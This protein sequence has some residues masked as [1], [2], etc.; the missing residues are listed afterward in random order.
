MSDG[1]NNTGDTT[2]DPAQGCGETDLKGTLT[3]PTGAKERRAKERR[4]WKQ[5]FLR[6]LAKTGN[7]TASARRA[8]INPKHAHHCYHKWPKFAQAWDR[9]MVQAVDSLEKAAWDR[10][11]DGLDKPIYQ[12]GK[13]VGWERRYSDT[14][15]IF[16]L[17]GR[18]PEV[19]GEKRT[20]GDT[21]VNV[22]VQVN[23]GD[24]SGEPV[25]LSAA[26]IEAARA[27][28]A[29]LDTISPPKGPEALPTADPA[30]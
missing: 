30:G 22:G 20:G 28:L 2:P 3:N 17:K 23:Q 16:L 12:G 8:G 26:D 25:S 10:A 24:G 18:R 6:A 19:F 14:L 7:V 21:T 29:Q 27:L 9:A 5:R 1:E 4:N 11:R 13:L 15:L